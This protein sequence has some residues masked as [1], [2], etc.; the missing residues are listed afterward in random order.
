MTSFGPRGS[1]AT[2]SRLSRAWRS[3]KRAL[4]TGQF[5]AAVFSSEAAAPFPSCAF[6]AGFC[7]QGEAATS[8]CSWGHW[9]KVASHA[10]HAGP[11]VPEDDGEGLR[12]TRATFFCGGL[13]EAWPSPKERLDLGRDMVGSSRSWLVEGHPLPGRSPPPCSPRSSAFWCGG[14][15]AGTWWLEHG[16][17]RVTGCAVLMRLSGAV[18][19]CKPLPCV[20]PA[21]WR[22]AWSRE[23]GWHGCRNKRSTL[24]VSLCWDGRCRFGGWSDASVARSG[25]VAGWLLPS[26]TRM[27]GWSRRRRRQLRCGSESFWRPSQEWANSGSLRSEGSMVSARRV[28]PRLVGSKQRQLFRR[29]G[30]APADLRCP[31][32]RQAWVAP[33]PSLPN[34]SKLEEYGCSRI[35]QLGPAGVRRAGGE[36]EWRRCPR[37][38]CSF[39]LQNS[40][41]VLCA[42]RGRGPGGALAA[43][44]EA[45]ARQHG[46]RTAR[47][48]LSFRRMLADCTSRRRR[49][50]DAQQQCYSRTWP[51]RSTLLFQNQPWAP[52]L[53]S[54][55]KRDEVFDGHRGRAEGPLGRVIRFE[56][57]TIKRQDVAVCWRR[58]A[59]E[60]YR[61]PWFWVSGSRKQV[62]TFFRT[63]PGDPLADLM[64]ALTSLAFQ[65]SLEHFLMQVGA[66]VRAPR[67]C[68]GIFGAGEMVQETPPCPT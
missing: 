10:S 21:R 23:I 41:G 16:R 1:Q 37:R 55:R 54:S 57:T 25:G 65:E 68:G 56:D 64:F 13:P 42:K 48:A 67:R 17:L 31:C 66:S 52:F 61:D 39:N 44:A 32:G 50:R 60:R 14:G 24:W 62:H 63:R 26:R 51:A 3:I 59:P 11:V 12:A 47:G 30:V 58:M 28:M 4:S 36:V 22:T 34:F 15:R 35:W 18:S 29:R 40:R 38:R 9:A 45:G 53:L 33:M 8:C 7:R 46:A 20:R 49:G 27:A 19:T 2:R 5:L 6:G 43:A